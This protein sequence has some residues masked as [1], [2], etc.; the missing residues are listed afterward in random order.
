ML[1]DNFRLVIYN[2]NQGI[3]D[4]GVILC[5]YRGKYFDSNG[6]LNFESESSAILDQS[7]DLAKGGYLASSTVDN[8]NKT[9]PIVEAD[10]FIEL[11]FTGHTRFPDGRVL[12][13]LQRA[14]ADTPVFT[15]DGEIPE[16][17]IIA[18]I[19]TDDMLKDKYQVV[20]TA[21]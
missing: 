9:N 1:P 2:G 12:V 4:S 5:K 11:D 21:R 16:K 3:I 14:T 20:V 15:T 8:G 19:F 18:N 6:K 10:F 17:D 7:S 13:Y